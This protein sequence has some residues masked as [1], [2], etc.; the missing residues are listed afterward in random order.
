MTA[1]GSGASPSASSSLALPLP[2]RDILL[3]PTGTPALP[4]YTHH[5]AD[6]ICSHADSTPSPLSGSQDL[7]DLFELLPLYETY[8]RPYVALPSTAPGSPKGKE[9][10]P[11]GGTTTLGFSIAGVRI[12]GV[13]LAGNA[14]ADDKAKKAKMDKTYTHLVADIPGRNTIKKDKHL[15]DCV[16]NPDIQPVHIQP[17][18]ASNLRGAFS[19]KTGAIPGFDA[20]IWETEVDVPKRKVRPVSL[21]L[22]PPPP[23]L[24]PPLCHVIWF[25]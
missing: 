23:L 19:L 7:L 1:N 22:L 25:E 8:V 10:E 14:A 24:L 18:D 13:A 12:G 2:L 15:R 3:T 21:S 4:P 11:S 17:F 6:L 20:M 16:L 9:R 5:D